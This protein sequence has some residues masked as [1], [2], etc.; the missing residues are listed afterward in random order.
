MTNKATDNIVASQEKEQT[1][2]LLGSSPVDSFGVAPF[3]GLLSPQVEPEDM[4]D[5]Q[6]I[7]ALLRELGLV[8]NRPRTNHK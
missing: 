6:V 3:E 8:S 5:Y 1:V 7:E 2:R 4:A